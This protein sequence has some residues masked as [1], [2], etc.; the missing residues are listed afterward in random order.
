MIDIIILIIGIGVISLVMQFHVRLVFGW[1]NAFK[2][3]AQSLKAFSPKD[4][5]NFIKSVK[6]QTL[7]KE[8]KDGYSYQDMYS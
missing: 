5:E 8:D 6:N 2:Q 3:T 1:V 7:N 4:M